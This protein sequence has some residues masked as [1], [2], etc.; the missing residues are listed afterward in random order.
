MVL[1]NPIS[2]IRGQQ[3]RSLPV[4]ADESRGHVPL[5]FFLGL[6]QA[7]GLEKSDRLIVSQNGAGDEDRTRDI[8]LG[9]EALYR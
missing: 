6:F 9:K 5:L 2:H 8:F 3:E 1:R 4:Y 7:A